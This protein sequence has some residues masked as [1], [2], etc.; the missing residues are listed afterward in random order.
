VDPRVETTEGWIEGLDRG[1][2]QS[3]RG[4][5]FARS[6]TGPLRL[7]ASQAVEPWPGTRSAKEYG[8][9]CPQPP[10]PFPGTR[11][12]ATSEAGSLVLNVDTPR[13]DAGR[14]PVLVWVHG[15]GFTTGSGSLPLY[16]GGR[17]AVRSD[18]VVVTLHYRLGALGYLYLGEHAGNTL[19][20][21]A[22]VGQLDQ[23]AALRWVRAN[24]AQFGGDPGNVTAF[25]ESAGAMAIATLL[26]MP[27]A[28]GLF[29]RAILQSGAAHNVLSPEIAA[30]VARALL[31]E[32]EIAPETLEKLWAV[33]AEAVVAAQVR[34]AATLAFPFPPFAPVVEGDNLPRAPLASIAR[35]DARDVP[36]LVGTNLDEA[37]LFRL[38]AALPETLT[39]EDLVR[40][41]QRLLPLQSTHT[42]RSVVDAYRKAREE[43]RASVAPSELLDA[44]ESD[45][46]FRIPAIRLSEAQCA[47]QRHTYMYL[48]T[49]PSPARR[50]ELGACHAVE[51]PFVFGT[52]DAPGIDRFSGAGAEAEWLAAQVM[53]VWAAF[54]RTGRPRHVAWSDWPAYSEPERC[55]FEIG[56]VPRLLS[57]PLEAERVCWEAVL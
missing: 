46:M 34:A 44:I 7:R 16:D 50:G 5:P 12:E 48:W 28:R 11:V 21:C 23:I 13:A 19:G 18:L 25:G 45:L 56:R 14:R 57:A 29:H 52:L 30:Q 17:L 47:H 41:L 2:Y 33:P 51:L 8:P 40:R 38:G 39:Q 43:R 54:A 32:L 42:A 27:A 36:V 49:W 35:G 4:I 22:N 1:R 24:I 55:T 31:K 10:S 26:G 53:D 3:F 37:K 20:A 15:G 9:A 6:P